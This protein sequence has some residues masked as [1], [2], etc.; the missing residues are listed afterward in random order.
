MKT[1]ILGNGFDLNLNFPTSYK[2][3]IAST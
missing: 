2:D 1:I 3:F